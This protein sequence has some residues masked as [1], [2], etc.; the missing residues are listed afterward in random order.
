M[1]EPGQM[2]THG[3][4]GFVLFDNLF[5]S[6]TS[7]LY[8]YMQHTSC[9]TVCG[10]NTHTYCSLFFSHL[11]CFT[12]CA[13]NLEQFQIHAVPRVGGERSPSETTSHCHI[14]NAQRGEGGRISEIRFIIN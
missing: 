14:Q 11:S 4:N 2:P 13:C 7:K 9:P 10:T 12:K 1:A 6:S 5:I 8:K 3:M